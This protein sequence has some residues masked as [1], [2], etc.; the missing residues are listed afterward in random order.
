MPEP[1]TA[2]I[3]LGVVFALVLVAGGVLVVR[4]PVPL[5]ALLAGL[6]LVVPAAGALVLRVRK[7]GFPDWVPFGVVLVLLVSFYALFFQPG[8]PP[9]E[10]AHFYGAYQQSN[11]LLPGMDVDDMR[12]VDHEFW[13]AQV[14]DAEG[15]T[16]ERWGELGERFE[17]A[18][19]SGAVDDL[20]KPRYDFERDPLQTKL[21]QVLG[22]AL[23]R[24][25][26]WG[27]VAMFYIG[28][29][30]GAWYAAALV[31]A[32]VA[33]TPVGRNVMAA[34]A[35]LPMTLHTMGSYSYDGAILGFAFLVLALVLR[36]RA[37]E[38][39]DAP[40]CVA[41]VVVGGLLAPCKVVYM[42]ILLLGL[43]V[44]GSKFS[45]RRSELA[46][47][48]AVVLV[49]LGAL[50]L[51]RLPTILAALGIVG[52]AGIMPD[53]QGRTDFWTTGQALGNPAQTLA[54]YAQTFADQT[55][56]YLES[57]VGQ[58]LAH[59]QENLS[60]PLAA[61]VLYYAALAVATVPARDDSQVLCR[62][63]RIALAV[64]FAWIV[65]SVM[66]A[67]LMS[68]TFPEESV[69]HGVQGR[70]FLPYVPCALLALRGVG[71]LR[72]KGNAFMPLVGA[73]GAGGFLVLAYCASQM[74][75]AA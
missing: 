63:W 26:G 16:W 28:R 55:G 60:L 20:G 6:A 13:E 64:L 65:L 30:F 12:V 52:Q 69:I 29:L 8:T 53:R 34:V 48:A 9:D 31:I 59:F 74:W 25:L 42:P 5:V 4:A 68:W 67:L 11:L 17:L 70:Y 10:D 15:Q 56:F 23:A 21:P 7:N 38:K 41:A 40:T 54:V 18:A 49:P 37:S 27:S 1:R 72:F 71:G 62:T 46:F 44:P 3:C 61:V 45:S 43:L 39:V 35:L 14:L 51:F 47:K 57:M 50:V 73:L 2:L 24:L 32:A 58:R 36:L 66:T 19:S 75:L 22:I 33:L